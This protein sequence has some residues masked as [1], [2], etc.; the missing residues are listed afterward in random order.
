MRA[1]GGAW[2][3]WTESQ[4]AL[5]ASLDA[6][7][8][9]DVVGAV[10]PADPR[11][12]AAVVVLAEQ[13]QRRRLAERDARLGALRVQTAPDEDEAVRVPLARDARRAGVAW[14]D[15]RLRRQ[16]HQRAH[17]RVAQDRVRRMTGRFDAAD[18]VL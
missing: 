17:D 13:H 6:R 11:L 8:R 4:D 5:A 18:R 3:R 7:A 14:V 15:D 1:T 12:R 10:R 2:T 9:H 16:L